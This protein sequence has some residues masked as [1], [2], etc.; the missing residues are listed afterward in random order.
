MTNRLRLLCLSTAVSTLISFDLYGQAQPYSQGFLAT[1]RRVATLV[2]GEG[3]SALRVVSLNPMRLPVSF[4]VDKESTDTVTV[5]Y[6]VFQIRFPRSWMVVDAAMDREFDQKWT[7]WSDEV[8]TQIQSALRDAHFIVVTHE[9]HD[10]V[11]G[12]IR[13]PYLQRIQAHTLLNP[14][15]VHSLQEHPN[16]P[17]IKI[18]SLTASRYLVID[19]ASLLPLAPG[20]V[21]IKAAGHTPGSQMVYVRLASG[22][23]IILAGDV[24]WHMSGI[25][26]QRQ[27]P[28]AST[29]EFGGEDRDAIALQLQWLK[30]ISDSGIV[31]TVAH[32]EDWIRTLVGRGVL[33]RGFDFRNP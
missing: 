28:V 2:P 20:V 7:N 24:A 19:Y 33:V 10:H 21:L 13:S 6:T 5:S 23:E 1:V 32:D 12:V 29:Q 4:M 18:D 25:K 9:H 15:Q 3:P 22:V 17:L 31:V 11:G 8:Y 26:L 16:H 14:A 27:K 30:A